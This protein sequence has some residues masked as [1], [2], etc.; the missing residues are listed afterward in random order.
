[1]PENLCINCNSICSGE[2]K[3]CDECLEKNRKYYR[4]KYKYVSLKKYKE[5][6]INRL[7]TRCSSLCNN[8]KTMCENCLKREKLR[9]IKRRQKAINSGL[10]PSCCKRVK[11]ENYLTCQE[12]INKQQQWRKKIGKFKTKIKRQEIKKI[13]FDHYGHKCVCCGVIGDKF[14]SIDHINNDGK[15]YRKSS[16]SATGNF[17][18]WIIKNNYPDNLQTL[19]FN[20]NFAKKNNNG[21]CPHM[22]KNFN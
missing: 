5:N 20:C 12:C 16:S 6:K 22:D 3:K 10:C 17:Y 2:Y 7:C 18:P 14:L 1:M 19:C 4:T 11:K 13:V 9:N 15:E 21:I 8:N